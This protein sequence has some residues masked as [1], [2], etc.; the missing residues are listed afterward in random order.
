M[1]ARVQREAHLSK[2]PAAFIKMLQEAAVYYQETAIYQGADSGAQP[3][4]G[5][6]QRATKAATFR[7]GGGG[8]KKKQ[9]SVGQKTPE[10]RS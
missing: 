9:R 2:D 5:K 8:P 10:V 4:V 3:P 6:R 1:G 7:V